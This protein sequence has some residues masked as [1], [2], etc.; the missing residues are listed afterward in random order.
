MKKLLSIITVLAL[1]VAVSSC[2]GKKQKENTPAGTHLHEDGSTHADHEEEAKPNQESFEV[3]DAEA[4]HDHDAEG[5][6]HGDGDA[7]SHETDAKHKH[8][9]GDEFDHEHPHEHN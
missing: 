1:V 8:E 9:S 2:K 3:I 5:H 4:E 7:H 6:E